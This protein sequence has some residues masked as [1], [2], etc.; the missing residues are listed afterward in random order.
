MEDKKLYTERGR[1]AIIHPSRTRIKDVPLESNGFDS[2]MTEQWHKAANRGI[3]RKDWY[4]HITITFATDIVDVILKSEPGSEER[5]IATVSA[6]AV[7]IHHIAYAARLAHVKGHRS[8]K[9][10][11]WVGLDVEFDDGY[12]L[13]GWLFG[14]VRVT[15]ESLLSIQSCFH[16]RRHVIGKRSEGSAYFGN[17]FRNVT[18]TNLSIYV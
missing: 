6:A 8:E 13:E 16:V 17:D 11:R 3:Q 15:F 9:F 12:A 2:L 4:H 5:L 18:H 1:L 10:K 7:F 14:G